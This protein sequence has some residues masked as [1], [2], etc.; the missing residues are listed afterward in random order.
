MSENTRFLA[1]KLLFLFID[2]HPYPCFLVRVKFPASPGNLLCFLYVYFTLGINLR[3]IKEM[4]VSMVNVVEL[5]HVIDLLDRFAS[6]RLVDRALQSEGLSRR[7]LRAHSE[8]LPY[9][10]EIA[11]IAN[12][13]RT[14]GDRQLGATLAT[15]FD[16]GAYNAYAGH[17]LGA[18]D[19]GS[20]LSRGQK[21]FPYI[22]PGSAIEIR[23]QGSHTLLGR[24]CDSLPNLVGGDHVDIGTIFILVQLVQQFLGPDWCPTW[25]EIYTEAP[26][27][28]GWMEEILGV[29]V[30]LGHQTPAIA[31]ENAALKTLNPHP[32]EPNDAICLHDLPI[33]MDLVPPRTTEALVRQA[34]SAK[35]FV[36]EMS[37][38]CIAEFLSMGRRT[39]QRALQAEGR[40]FRE[41]RAGF[42]ETR[43][44]S[45]LAESSLDVDKIAL[46]LG[47]KEPK[48]FHRA[49]RM[50][51]GFTPQAYRTKN[52][53]KGFEGLAQGE[54][55]IGHGT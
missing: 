7:A 18:D 14:L 10:L 2:I 27:H 28:K 50:W 13:A 9:K 23:N 44:R 52:R 42:L 43:A 29:P 36:G 38:E 3:Q 47:Y 20:A 31:I 54:R 15:Q 6:P 22:H 12:V 30:K 39:M 24:R 19:L 40:T 32:V 34:L 17:V 4:T 11:L 1:R 35:I 5:R 8:F 37:E 33:L 25:V 53:L 49:F 16:Y 55:R 51:T 41:I 21:A 45:L 46:H 26:G 48:S